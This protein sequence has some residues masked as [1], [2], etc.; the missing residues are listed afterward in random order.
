M[1]SSL[2]AHAEFVICDCTIE[3]VIKRMKQVLKLAQLRGKTALTNE[4]TILALLLAWSLLQPEVQHAREV[5]TQAAEQWALAHA[6]SQ[7]SESA[8]ESGEGATEIP[9]PT[10]SSWTTTALGVQT[11][12]LLVQG[13]WTVARLRD[14]LPF[15]S[16]FLCSR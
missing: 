9:R 12:R 11:L 6:A 2:P 13:F 3:L 5:L 8:P 16:R 15:L 14:C 1:Q 4:A 10:V 7:G